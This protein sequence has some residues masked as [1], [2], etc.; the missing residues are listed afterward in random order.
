M[1]VIETTELEQRLLAEA[2]DCGWRFSLEQLRESRRVGG[3]GRYW[4]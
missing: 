2:A 4:R 3:A 1:T